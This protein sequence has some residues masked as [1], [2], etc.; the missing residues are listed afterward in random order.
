MV[1]FLLVVAIICYTILHWQ[2]FDRD[3]I[4]WRD[5]DRIGYNGLG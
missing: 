5:K 2:N 1:Y 4:I 3:E